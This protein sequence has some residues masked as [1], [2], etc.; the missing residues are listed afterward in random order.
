MTFCPPQSTSDKRGEQAHALCLRLLTVRS[1]TRSEL[2]GQLDKRGYPEDVAESVLDRLAA[3]GLIDDADFAEQWV[4]SRRARAGKG[5]RALV[6]ELRTKGVDDDV[7]AAAV[8][9]I[10][11]G[12]ER[13]RAE[14]WWS[15][16]CAGRPSP[17]TTTPR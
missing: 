13:R 14:G 1:R 6:A 9:D 4:R 12:A 17:T 8:E 11:A 10:D 7:I 15:A 3:V 2:A 5:K 16:S